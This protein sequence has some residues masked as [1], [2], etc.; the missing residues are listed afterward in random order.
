MG[1]DMSLLVKLLLVGFVQAAE[2]STSGSN[3]CIER[4]HEGR[5]KEVDR[6]LW[7]KVVDGV[8][9]EYTKDDED[10]EEDNFPWDYCTPATAE[11]LSGGDV[12]QEEAVVL[13]VA[14]A[15]AEAV[16]KA[17]VLPVAEA[18]AEAVPEAVEL[19][20]RVNR[21]SWS[22]GGNSGFRPAKSN[23]RVASSLADT[24]C[25]RECEENFGGKYAC[26]V[27]VDKH[28][29]FF[30]SPEVPLKRQQLSSHNHLWC[31]SECVKSSAN[32][33]YECRTMFGYDRCSPAGDRSSTGKTCHSKCER[34]TENKHHPYQ[35]YTDKNMENKEDCGN[36]HVARAEKKVLEYTTDDKVCAGPC[37]QVGSETLCTYVDWSWNRV[38]QSGDL[39]LAEATC[40]CL[41][42]TFTLAIVALGAMFTLLA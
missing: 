23:K 42:L 27:N 38:T 5:R 28:R 9:T 6:V 25:I 40:G 18:V 26:E 3:H 32:H 35:C 19:P 10:I 29:N 1:M 24:K 37:T 20:E 13:P 41:S 14:E 34:S 4:C 17:V 22:E 33:Y 39:Q 36:W 11:A 21:T 2:W 31:I 16:A 12:Y 30:C 15:L 7:C 8:L